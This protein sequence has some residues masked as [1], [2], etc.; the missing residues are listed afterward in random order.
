MKHGNV[1]SKTSASLGDSEISGISLCYDSTS[2]TCCSIDSSISHYC[3][4]G[5]NIIEIEADGADTSLTCISSD[6]KYA[7]TG[8]SEGSIQFWCL[9]SSSNHEIFC[10]NN[11]HD[12]EICCINVS[13]CGKLFVTGS[14]D[15]SVRTWQL[16]KK[17]S[18]VFHF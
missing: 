14:I 12:H 3:L 16:R 2:F 15:G 13:T 18:T 7:V 4:D 11:A 1:I 17:P 9:S 8:S 6:G 5:Q 10:I